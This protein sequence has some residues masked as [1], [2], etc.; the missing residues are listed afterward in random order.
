MNKILI[1]MSIV[2]AAAL[3]TNRVK[4][5]GCEKN[6][7]CKGDRVC[8]NGMCMYPEDIAADSETP[9]QIPAS[10]DI[11]EDSGRYSQERH[12]APPVE[13]GGG[14]LSNLSEGQS[15][16]VVLLEEPIEEAM[17]YVDGQLVG[18]APWTGVVT[19]GS[20]NVRVEALGYVSEETDTKI[21]PRRTRKLD[22]DLR[23]EGP[24][25]TGPFSIAF[26]YELSIMYNAE[27]IGEVDDPF[28]TSS[29]YAFSGNFGYRIL[30]DPFWFELGINLGYAF[31]AHEGVDCHVDVEG[32]ESFLQLGILSRGLIAILE[33]WIYFALELEPGIT[34]LLSR[35]HDEPNPVGGYLALRL[36]ASFF[37]T[38]WLEFRVMPTG[39]KIMGT[40][41]IPFYSG[42]EQI[43]KDYIFLI[44]NFSLGISVHF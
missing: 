17:V 8:H 4:A 42:D 33:P 20:H 9:G 27:W 34:V 40:E 35:F 13:S 12:Y 23:K 2:A 11:G 3:C 32:M 36:G 7:D 19:P 37:A 18:T 38:H 10:G 1:T 44:Y 30:D 39:L 26:I 25:D 31:L 24:F 14:V 5:G 43:T 28:A 29:P 15:G 41:S 22:F 6:S 16:L 21:W